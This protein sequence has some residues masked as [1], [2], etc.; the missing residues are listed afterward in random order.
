MLVAQ[1]ARIFR[2][3][4]DDYHQIS[5]RSA[6]ITEVEHKGDDVTAKIA[7]QLN[8]T[9]ITPI[10]REDIY[11]LSNRLDDILDGVHGTIERMH[12]YH[13]EEPTEDF[14]HL[15]D[16]L[17]KSTSTLVD[18]I[19]MLRHMPKE[20][21][22]I[23]AGCAII[24]GCESEGDRLYRRGMARLF[25]ECA[26]PIEL[27]KWKEIWERVEDSIDVCEHVGKITKGVT[28]KYA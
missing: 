22:K 15:V 2:T 1:G 27:I 21:D 3:L 5:V 17:V 4:M 20:T 11:L 13:T 12:L 9:F 23:L 6:E 19:K 14:V 7:D 8:R 25:N 18:V 10:D 28:M 16:Q 26:D 24:K